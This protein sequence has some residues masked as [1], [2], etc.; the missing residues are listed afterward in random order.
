MFANHLHGSVVFHSHL[1]IE[2]VG[3]IISLNLFSGIPFGGLGDG[4]FEGVSVVYIEHGILGLQISIQKG[5]DVDFDRSEYFLDITPSFS[6][7]NVSM[8]NIRVPC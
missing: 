5:R 7:K 3:S 6:F 8:G 4:Y 1:N 2:A